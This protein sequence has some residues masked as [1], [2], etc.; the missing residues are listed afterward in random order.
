MVI[1][2][3]DHCKMNLGEL[4]KRLKD[5]A[6]GINARDIPQLNWPAVIKLQKIILII[7]QMEV[8]ELVGQD[9]Y[10]HIRN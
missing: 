8:P 3:G 6:D 10:E 5:L 1:R 2:E 4:I 9:H 7:K